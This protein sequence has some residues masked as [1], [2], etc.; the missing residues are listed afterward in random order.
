MIALCSENETR[1]W[2]A[3]QWIRLE[4]NSLDKWEGSLPLFVFDSL[5]VHISP[6]SPFLFIPVASFFPSLFK[7]NSRKCGSFVFIPFGL[8][9]SP[10]SFSQPSVL[11]DYSGDGPVKAIPIIVFE[12]HCSLALCSSETRLFSIC[13]LYH[14]NTGQLGLFCSDRK[15]I[16]FI[17]T[18]ACYRS[19]LL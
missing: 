1:E 4:G 8:S 16:T 13:S 9:L 17:F 14:T 15:F 5:N 18:Q 3:V 6:Y 12:Q 2:E 10:S 11:S 19:P 7:F